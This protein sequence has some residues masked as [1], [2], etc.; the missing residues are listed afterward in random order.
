METEITAFFSSYDAAW[1]RHNA[2]AFT[3]HFLENASAH[4]FMLDGKKSELNS[5]AEMLAFYIPS[6][7]SLQS[8]P[9]V[10]HQTTIHRTQNASPDLLIV[11][12]D[13]LITEQNAEGATATVRKWAVSFLLTKT[14]AGW[15][16]F[17][18]RG[19]DRPLA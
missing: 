16:I 9:T 14:E 13:A 6:F 15:K 17:S 8:R 4:F 12:G 3:S 7:Q 19:S 11:D 5:R 10:A 18:L 1:N 2:E